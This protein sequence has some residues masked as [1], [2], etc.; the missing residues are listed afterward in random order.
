MADSD[1]A[2][3]RI[4][5]VDNHELVRAGLAIDLNR[6]PDLEVVGI[7]ADG[8]QA[9]VLTQ[10]LLPDVIVMDLKMPVMDGL[11]AS[12]HIKHSYPSVRIIAYTS[13]EDPQTEVVVQTVPIDHFCYKD[14]DTEVLVGL[15]RQ[16]K[17]SHQSKSQGY[18]D[19]SK[20]GC[21]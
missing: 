4:L 6:Y 19:E 12:E 17:S 21:H 16:V 9:I 20:N 5:I 14:T 15:I 2:R 10:Q 1:P 13:L 11:T 8:Q 3:I 7:A 18:L